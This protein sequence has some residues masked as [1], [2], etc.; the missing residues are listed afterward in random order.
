ME[1]SSRPAWESWNTKEHLEYDKKQ[2]NKKQQ[3]I[4]SQTGYRPNPPYHSP[5][6]IKWNCWPSFKQL[7]YP[8]A[9]GI[10]YVT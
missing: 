8:A 2:I 10:Y 4:Y 6:A 3:V 9:K 5:V 1:M 7:R